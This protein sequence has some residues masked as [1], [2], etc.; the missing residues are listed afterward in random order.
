MNTKPLL[1]KGLAL[2]IEVFFDLDLIVLPGYDGNY[3][4]ENKL[5]LSWNKSRNFRI[6]TGYK[7]IVGEF[8]YG[9]DSRMFPYLPVLE[10]WVPVLE[11]QW[12]RNKK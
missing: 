3:S 4:M 6:M 8:P 12:A 9:K 2:K 5:L 11:F 7:F 1:P 10:R